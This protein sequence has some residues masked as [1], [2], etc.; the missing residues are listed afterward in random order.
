MCICVYIYIHVFLYTGLYIV[1]SM[2]L[3]T[4][5]NHNNHHHNH[6]QQPTQT[7]YINIKKQQRRFKIG[8]SPPNG[9]T[10][11]L[12]SRNHHTVQEPNARQGKCNFLSKLPRGVPHR[13]LWL[14]LF[15]WSQ[16]FRAKH[17]PKPLEIGKV[18][19]PHQLSIMIPTGWGSNEVEETLWARVL[20]HAWYRFHCLKL[21]CKPMEPWLEV[22]MY[23]LFNTFNTISSSFLYHIIY[24]YIS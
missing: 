21:T 14:L 15:C 23:F 11:L 24:I 20:N 10:E 9:P 3:A 22:Y 1:K 6:N 5:N 2:L 17:P 13:I 18:A 4:M 7:T 19:K 12:S 8:K 16:E